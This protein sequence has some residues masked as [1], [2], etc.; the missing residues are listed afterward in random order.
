MKDSLTNSLIGQKESDKTGETDTVSNDEFMRALFGK[1]V[2]EIRPMVVSFAGDP[3][4]VKPSAWDG[5]AW[6]RY[7]HR[8]IFI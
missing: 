7:F 4:L 8:V 2:G 3:R 6:G 5:D 1:P